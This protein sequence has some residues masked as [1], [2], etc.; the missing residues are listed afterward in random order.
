MK[1]TIDVPGSI[2]FRGSRKEGLVFS[3]QGLGF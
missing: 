2:G 1:V 3:V